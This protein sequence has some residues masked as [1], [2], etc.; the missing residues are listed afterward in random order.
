MNKDFLDPNYSL[1]KDG[2]IIVESAY[3]PPDAELHY[4]QDLISDYFRYRTFRSGAVRMLQFLSLEEV[5]RQSR[6]LFWNSNITASEDLSGLGLQFSLPFTRKEVMDLVGRVTSLGI[7]PHIHGAGLDEYGIKVFNGF[8]QHWRF[9]NNDKVEKFWQLLYGFV[10]GTVPLYIGFN[11]EK[12]KQSFLREYDPTSGNFKLDVKDVA[13]WNDV[14]S[15]LVPVEDIYLPKIYERNIQKQGKIIWKT[16]MDPADFH[17]EFGMYPESAMVQPG[18]RI[19]E[20]SLYYRL[21]G[22]TGVTTLNKIEVLRGYDIDNDQFGIV[23]NGILLNKLGKGKQARVSPMPQKHKMLPFAWGIGEALDE[24]LAY[25]LPVPFKVK[26]PHK[27][28]NLQWTMLFERELRLIDPPILSSD[29]ETPSVIFGQKKIIPVGDVNAYHEIDIKPAGNDF[30]QTLNSTQNMMSGFAQGGMSSSIPSVQPKTAAETDAINQQKQQA[31]STTL[32]MYYDLIRQ[33][34]ML[35]LKT[36][37]QYYPLEKYNK[38]KGDVIKS[39]LVPNMPL[40]MGG[41]GDLE[42]RLV[43]KVKRPM[44]LFMESI[45]KG[46]QNGRMTEIIEVPVEFIQQELEFMISKIELEPEQSSNMEKAMYI[47]SVI[48]PMIQ[49]YIPAGVADIGKT[50]LQHMQKLGIHPSD[51]ASSKILP[52]LMGSWGTGYLG[53]NL[54]TPNLGGARGNAMGNMQQSPI[55]QLNGG[56][57]NGGQGQT[58]FGSPQ[59]QNLVPQAQ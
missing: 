16:Q 25:G 30:F 14:E 28:M 52:Q 47:Q 32:L 56:Q 22:G 11:N 23:A 40:S 35:V 43:D 4:V 39:L 53:Q 46:I 36:M 31:M 57:S 5:W 50:F 8:L 17:R 26:D 49:T 18:S 55:G 29:L 44:D 13:W 10:N 33:E 2:K 24:K 37:L 19:S 3:N 12:R 54:I 1:G 41:T 45:R 9:K 59:M 34:I 21:L 27:L 48:Q 51:F 15:Y 6:E 20:D 42:L 7:K 38:A 58:P